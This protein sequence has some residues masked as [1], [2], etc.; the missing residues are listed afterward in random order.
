MKLILEM[1]LV[2][3]I[4]SL[5]HPVKAVVSTKFDSIKL[6]QNYA[7]LYQYVKHLLLSVSQCSNQNQSVRHY[8]RIVCQNIHSCTTLADTNPCDIYF[9]QDGDTSQ[10]LTLGLYI[11]MLS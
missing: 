2:T 3:L 1:T 8:H 4:L 7:P 5:N 6:R 9:Q 10:I 11:Q